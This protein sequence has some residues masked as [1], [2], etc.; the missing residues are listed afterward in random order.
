MTNNEKLNKVKGAFYGLAIGDAMGATTEFMSAK[1]I[2]KKY[3]L[4]GVTKII[5]GGWLNVKPG[6]VTDDTQ[7]SMC[8]ARAILSSTE[9]A[10]TITRVNENRFLACCRANFLGWYNSGPIDIGNQCR[11][12]L[13]LF[14]KYRFNDMSDGAWTGLW[15]R[16][17]SNKYAYGNGSLMRAL[18]AALVGEEY[19]VAQGR[20]THNNKVCDQAI[21]KYCNALQMAMQGKVDRTV[22]FHRNNGGAAYETLDGACYWFARTKNF[23]DCIIGVVNDGG[24]ADTVGAVAGSIAGCYYGFDAIPAELVNALDLEVRRALDN[25][26]S[27]YI[28]LGI[29]R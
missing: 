6:A 10:G 16:A 18:P 27:K 7:M 24:D 4:E 26:V 12:V 13:S 3:G 28:E 23:A 8:V 9:T 22:K 15:Y 29:V 2:R 19:A 21:R 11:R 1:E 25:V 5:G 14:Y 17:A 20:L